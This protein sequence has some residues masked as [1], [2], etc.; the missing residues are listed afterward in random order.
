MKR[1]LA[2]L[3]ALLIASAADASVLFIDFTDSYTTAS[4]R[5]YCERTRRK[6]LGAFDRQS[7]PGGYLVIPYTATKT[8]WVQNAYHA[9]ANGTQIQFDAVWLINFTPGRSASGFNPDSLFKMVNAYA[10]WPTRPMVCTTPEYVPSGR[11]TQTAVCSTGV[12]TNNAQV[13]PPTLSY[14]IYSTK[15]DQVWRSNGIQTIRANVASRPPGIFRAILAYG[16]ASSAIDATG[17]LLCANCDAVTRATASAAES[18][19][20]WARAKNATDSCQIVMA[21]LGIAAHMGVLLT[22]RAYL[23]SLTHGRATQSP[24][25]TAVMLSGYFRTDANAPSMTAALIGLGLGATTDTLNQKAVADSIYALRAFGLTRGVITV[26]TDSAQALA[27]QRSIIRRLG[28]G[29][30]VTPQDYAGTTEA[31]TSGWFGTTIGRG[32]QSGTNAGR[33]RL[34]D[35]W[36]TARAARTWLPAPSACAN[37]DSTEPCLFSWSRQRADS[38]SKDLGLSGVSSAWWP[39]NGDWSPA[40]LV[41]AN[42]ASLDT[43][44]YVAYTYGGVR[45]LLTTPLL[46]DTSPDLY[47]FQSG[48]TVTQPIGWGYQPSRLT[49]R[50]PATGAAVGS[51]RLLA[52]RGTET[53]LSDN[54]ANIHDELQEFCQGWV[55]GPPWF[56]SAD[57]TITGVQGNLYRHD[58]YVPL[59]VM[60]LP[61]G[62]LGGTGDGTTPR[63]YGWWQLKG[64]VHI[65]SCANSYEYPGK[66]IAEIVYPEDIR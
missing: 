43:V 15:G 63:A 9:L 64:L 18:L 29:W 55:S 40:R 50:N 1:L 45:A 3:A 58:F 44:L 56:S 31:F 12:T 28:P 21:D 27:S 30:K 32:V 41:R 65:I 62:L 11:W 24:L 14:A 36:E 23:D 22:T 38:I 4:E 33:F 47:G 35:L 7:C 46:L 59:D 49:V 48:S 66:R 10:T 8:L 53:K 26:Q 25:N 42:S 57:G 54:P 19:V 6:V 52:T 13:F 16:V 20:V 37:T 2:A 34:N 60:A 61:V 39:P 17:L 5:V 51:I